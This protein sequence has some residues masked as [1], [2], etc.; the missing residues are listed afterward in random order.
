MP[1][2]RP[3]G[4]RQG[5]RTTGVFPRA[6]SPRSVF[7]DKPS[8]LDDDENVLR[9]G[10]TYDRLTLSSDK[11]LH[12]RPWRAHSLAHDENI[13]SKR[14]LPPYQRARNCLDLQVL[15]LECRFS[16]TCLQA[17]NSKLKAFEFRLLRLISRLPSTKL[18]V[19]NSVAILFCHRNKTLRPLYTCSSAWPTVRCMLSSS[20]FSFFFFK[21]KSQQAYLQG[22]ARCFT[23]E[24]RNI[25][26]D[27]SESNDQRA[28]CSIVR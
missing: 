3:S 6:S 12:H 17:Q 22:A 7:D 15:R 10:A 14:R 11:A 25:G 21:K 13:R 23:S 19:F 24:I 1:V 16:T 9:E 2:S 18:E 26:K 5:G 20:V 28:D 8:S 4:R 27:L